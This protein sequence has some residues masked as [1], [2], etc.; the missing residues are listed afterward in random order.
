MKDDF[1]AALAGAVVGLSL[2]ALFVAII[3]RAMHD[4]GRL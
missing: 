4:A 1:H 2:F 3:L